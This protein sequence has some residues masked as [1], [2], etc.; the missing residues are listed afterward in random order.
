MSYVPLDANTHGKLR[1]EH[2]RNHEQF[3]NAHY[4]PLLAAELGQA[5]S[6]Y[7]LVF[8]KNAET[9]QFVC[10]ALMGLEAGQNLHFQ[11]PPLDKY[12]PAH[13]RR[14]PFALRAAAGGAQVLIDDSHP[15]LSNETG[16]ALFPADQTAEARMQHFRTEIERLLTEER[17]TAAFMQALTEHN[18]LQAAS[19][20]MR[21]AD[22]RQH[23]IEGL[24][25]I[26]E[27]ALTVLADATVVEFHRRR[28]WGPIHASLYSLER[29][30]Q[31]IKLLEAGGTDK[32]IDYRLVLAQ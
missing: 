15:S 12:L 13:V 18:L 4:I 7:P 25:L 31:L 9:G 16:E 22:G 32:V 28:Y 5:G 8:I 1:Y 20:Q 17:V 21:Y 10:V 11:H 30:V 26:N 2:S 19:L 24:Y 29:I 6:H 23:K 14:G 3:R 27:Q